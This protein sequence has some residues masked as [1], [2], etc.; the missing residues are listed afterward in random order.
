MAHMIV[1][2]DGKEQ[3]ISI[4]RKLT[5]FGTDAVYDAQVLSNSRGILFTVM[6]AS[7]GQY[8]VM[9]NARIHLNGAA[10]KNNVKLYTCDRI[11]W[12]GGK[13]VFLASDL[14]AVDTDNAAAIA[15]QKSLEVLQTLSSSTQAKEGLQKLLD[16]LVEISGAEEGYLLSENNDASEWTMLA[17]SSEETEKKQRKELFSNTILK[18]AMGK[19]RPI[20]IQSIIGHEFSSAHSIIEAR[21]F[22]VACFP[23][24]IADRIVGAVFLFTRT[25]GRSIKKDSL[26]ALGILAAQ[27]ALMIAS[28]QKIVDMRKENRALKAMLESPKG[29]L[30][31]SRESNSPMDAVARKIEKLAS[32]P[33]SILILG[34]TGTGK[35]V[36][37]KELHRLS[38]RASGPFVAINC[39]AIPAALLES[40]L[41]GYER[42]A[43]TGAIKAHDGKFAQA[44]GGTLFLDEI[45]DLPL[46]LQAKLLRVLQ[47]KKVEPLGS[48]R[49]VAV[50]ARIVCATH[51]NLQ[52]MIRAQQFRQ[53]LYF[54]LAG[55]TL[56]LPP[57]RNRKSDIKVLC[58]YFLMKAE[59]DKTLSPDA[60]EALEQSPWPGNVRELEQVVTRAAMLCDHATIGKNDLEMQTMELPIEEDSM[61]WEQ[62][63]SLDDAQLAFTRDYVNKWLDKYDGNRA[64]VAKRLGISDRTLYRILSTDRIDR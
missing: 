45:G 1:V 13:A 18:E 42:G 57:L 40:I 2:C 50:D 51:R 37:A 14:S 33:L 55:A 17:T 12:N 53:D 43:F 8:E 44:D 31:F 25:P 46:E 60:L 23:M 30:I 52:L 10:I 64:Q 54:R 20:Y 16:A 62:F 29:T 11:E 39:A 22:S 28:N 21:L 9:P 59:S 5:T 36:V 41:F 63:D 26:H 32:T 35:E 4:K 6:E 49:P 24:I 48:V 47:E 7:P 34:E 3:V 58:D 15:A 27:S 38:S 19:R 56:D 61:F